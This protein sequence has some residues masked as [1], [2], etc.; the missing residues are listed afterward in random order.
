M[1]LGDLKK[2]AEDVAKAR[3]KAAEARAKAARQVARRPVVVTGRG[4]PLIQLG[5]RDDKSRVIVGVNLGGPQPHRRWVP[6]RYVTRT[7]QILL[8]PGRYEWRWQQVEVEP[9][10]YETRHVPAVEEILY[11]SQGNPHRI[12][13]ESGRTEKVWV[14]A[15][16]E[17]RR[18]KVW[19]PPRYGIR[20]TRV[21]VPGHWVYRPRPQPGLR[22]G[23][24]I[25]F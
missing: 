9:A 22:L 18:V 7:E 17:L 13:I 8:E 20:E 25:R 14:P 6:G 3:R 24:V 12:V 16:Y 21:W 4:G 2:V 5:R 10:H 1:V 11:D 23:A 15:R 19:V